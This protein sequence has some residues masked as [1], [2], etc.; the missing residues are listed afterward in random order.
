MGQIL[1]IFEVL[2]SRQSHIAGP[3]QSPRRIYGNSTIPGARAPSTGIIGWDS[4][5][6]L[7]FLHDLSLALTWEESIEFL[8]LK[9]V[10]I[11]LSSLH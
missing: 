9:K 8:G 7:S 3:R 4:S 1:P 5:L 10:E 2:F 6:T 11:F